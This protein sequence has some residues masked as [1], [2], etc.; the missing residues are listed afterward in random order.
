MPEFLSYPFMW[1]A[2]A[3]GLMAGAVC[4]F[5]GIFILLRK[6]AFFS[7]A[8]S[9]S[10]LAGIAVGLLL[11]LDPDWSLT[12]FSVLVALGMGWVS[13]R[14]ALSPDAVIGVFF[15]GTMAL[16]VVL[17]GLL[18]GY[19]ADLFAYL[20]GDILGVGR[21][22]L[23]RQG[24]LGAVVVGVLVLYLG[25]FVKI[26]LNRDLAKAEGLP[27][28]AYD[29]LFMV[30]IAL[31]VAV[32]MKV[33]G[34]L[35]VGALLILSPASARNLSQNLRQLFALSLLFA[36]ISVVLGLAGSYYLEAASGPSIVLTLSLIFLL[37][38][39]GRRLRAR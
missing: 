12:V 11:G 34:A 18:K 9:H 39:F 8:L 15:T 3:A 30:L 13:H 1:R 24:A 29:Y 31:T 14:T 21:E 28:E 35:L 2:L 36:L 4:A 33:V 20:F 17:I 7:A 38:L 16:G 22:D 27:V 5:V 23:V 19:R 10:A 37:T 26:G 6:M 25:R 32:S